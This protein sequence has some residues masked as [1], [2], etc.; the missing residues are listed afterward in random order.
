MV[1]DLLLNVSSDDRLE[2]R[3]REF[4]VQQCLRFQEKENTSSNALIVVLI[5]SNLRYHAIAALHGT[6]RPA[7]ARRFDTLFY[8]QLPHIVRH[9]LGSFVWILGKNKKVK[10][11]FPRSFKPTE[12]ADHGDTEIVKV[13]IV[14]CAQSRSDLFV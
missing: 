12:R 6:E 5:P 1:C 7:F 14:L 3:R 4:L 2:N 9:G 13:S 10:I 8:D 11:R